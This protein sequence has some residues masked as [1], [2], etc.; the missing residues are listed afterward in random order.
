MLGNPWKSMKIYENIWKSIGNDESPQMTRS[1]PG[2]EQRF[3][4]G[5]QVKL[6]KSKQILR[7]CRYPML[8][9]S[10]ASSTFQ[11][12]HCMHSYGVPS[13]FFSPCMQSLQECRPCLRF[14]WIRLEV[15]LERLTSRADR[16]NQ[17]LSLIHIW[18]CR[19]CALC[20]SRWSPYH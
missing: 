1:Q 19:R 12:W 10:N 3:L 5:Q 20:R 17:C 7:K 9:A 8:S 16:E 18:R 2:I 6:W 14:H 11:K 13:F 4:Y 15:L